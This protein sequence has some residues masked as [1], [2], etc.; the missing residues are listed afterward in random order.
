MTL[1]AIDVHGFGGGFTLGT[2][3]AGFELQAKMSLEVGFGVM[4]TLAN[5]HLLGEKWESIAGDPDTWEVFDADFVFGNPPCSGFSTLSPKAFRGQDS[6]INKYMWQLVEYAAKVKPEIVAWESVQQTFRQGLPLMR[7][8]HDKLEEVT[9]EKYT[10]THVLHNN[11]SLGGVS[12]RRRY[13]WVAS[14][15]PFGVEREDIAAVP[16]FGDMLRD[17]MPLGLTMERQSY[18]TAWTRHT[19][20]C[21]SRWHVSSQKDRPECE[22]YVEVM[23]SSWWCRNQIH[24]GTG[25]VDGHDILRSPTI[26]RALECFEKVDWKEGENQS[27]VLRKYYEQEGELPPSWSY[28][29]SKPYFDEN[30]EQ[31]I[32]GKKRDGTV[33]YKTI[34]LPKSERL[35]ETDFAMGHNQLTRWHWSRMARVITG[36]ACHLILHPKLDRTLTQRE[37]ARVQGFPDA[38]NIWPVRN[39]PDLGPGWGKGVPVQAGR[40]IAKWAHNSI[41]GSPGTITGQPLDEYSKKLCDAYGVRDREFVI[42]LTNDYKPFTKAIGDPG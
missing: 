15:V 31:V 12:I 27:A 38:W 34:K 7:K 4:N 8:L 5:R 26:E 41:S 20:E 23:N 28:Q 32:I 16:T 3:Q 30:G 10:L 24:D 2:V 11:A 29:T 13:F 6:S 21:D 22:C 35:V 33:Q 37:A 17:L 36:G 9:G 39:A 1:K 25:T 40:W 14:R 18:P 42:D 19:S